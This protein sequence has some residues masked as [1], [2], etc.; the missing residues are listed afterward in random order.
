MPSNLTQDSDYTVPT[1]PE[2]FCFCYVDD[3]SFYHFKPKAG[4]SIISMFTD[5]E[6][7]GAISV[8]NDYI[9]I[10]YSYD[11]VFTVGV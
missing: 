6:G 11:F 7:G 3:S 10:S 8:S 4:V 2:D 5:Y 9:L 1:S